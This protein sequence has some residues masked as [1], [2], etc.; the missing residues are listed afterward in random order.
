MRIAQIA[1]LYESVPPR[2]YG[3]TERI[4]S[5]LTEELVAMGHRVTLFASGD[6]RTHAHLVCGCPEALRLRGD[7]L[8]PIA[9]HV[10]H[11]RR[12]MDHA[13]EFDVIHNHMDY[14]GFPLAA[15]SL[16]PVVTTLHGR[17]DIPDLVPVFDAFPEVEL[18]SI[19]DAQREPLPGVRFR[20]TVQHGLPRD[21]LRAGD[22]SGGY[23]AFLGRMSPEKRPDAA[24]RIARR[25][26][27][28]LR[29]AA[30]VDDADKE[31]FDAVVR[32]LLD[33]SLIEFVGEIDDA[34]K[35][36]FLGEARALVMP[37]DW[38]E[39]F[40]IVMIEALACGTPVVA[41]VCGSVPEIIDDGVTG[42]VCANEDEMARAVSRIDEIERRRCRLEF[43]SRF[44]A[45]HMARAYVRV[46]HDVLGNWE[47]GAA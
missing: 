46:Y 21:L 14:L 3:G 44:T 26:G 20:S 19:S 23:L 17:L 45:A 41:R 8:D 35:E 27:M 4:V 43:E 9:H 37:I 6:S 33:T 15:A 34:H 12:V 42:F 2:F 47:R 39:P 24:I 29:M 1:P 31:F 38:P 25:V 16:R 13:R 10:A 18:L 30:K 40:G 22:G 32:P 28:P 5:F 7:V 11:L 36:Q